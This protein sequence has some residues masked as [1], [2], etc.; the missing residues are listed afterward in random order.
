MK[1]R[2]NQARSHS[3]IGWGNLAAQPLAPAR[4][5]PAGQSFSLPGA[6]SQRAGAEQQRALDPSP[7]TGASSTSPQIGLNRAMPYINWGVT[8]ACPLSSKGE[9]Y[10]RGPKA[11]E[12]ARGPSKGRELAPGPAF[13]PMEPPEGHPILKRLTPIRPSSLPCPPMQI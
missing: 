3:F 4:E 8:N 12:A 1:K 9:P 11:L 2:Q 13:Q 6:L 10:W 5:V 7:Q